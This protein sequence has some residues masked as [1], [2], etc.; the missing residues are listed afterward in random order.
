MSPCKPEQ[1]VH[2][3]FLPASHDVSLADV[4]GRSPGQLAHGQGQRRRGGAGGGGG[5]AG[6]HSASVGDPG[7]GLEL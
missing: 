2:T 3:Y 4:P 5:G 7:H 1:S 6:P